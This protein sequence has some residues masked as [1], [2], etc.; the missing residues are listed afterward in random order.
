MRS[1]ERICALDR[2]VAIAAVLVF[3]AGG[4]SAEVYVGSL[5]SADGGLG[6]NWFTEAEPAVLS[7]EVT[8]P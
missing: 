3:A 5:N 1:A 2:W 4:L 6:G 7:W 8:H